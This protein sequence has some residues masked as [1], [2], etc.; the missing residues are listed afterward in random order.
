M[1]KIYNSITQTFLWALVLLMAAPAFSQPITLERSDMPARNQSY[2]MSIGDS[3]LQLDPSLTGP[4]YTWDFSNLNAVVQQ[5]DSFLSANDLPLTLRFFFPL[6]LTFPTDNSLVQYI[7]TPDSL[8]GISVGEAYQLYELKSNVMLGHGL[9]STLQGVPLTLQNQPADTVYRFPLNYGDMDSAETQGTFEFPGVAYYEQ[10]RKRI[11]EVDGWGTVQT[12]YGTF[13][14]L[15]IK[16]QISGRDSVQLD[17]LQ[18]FSIDVPQT[19]E[20]KWLAKD[21]GVPILQI[22][23]TTTGQTE[24]VS[25][26]TY[27]DSARNVLVLSTD[28]ENLFG[29]VSC[30]PNPATDQ[31]KIQWQQTQ[32]GP[33]TLS[34]YDLSGKIRY[35]ETIAGEQERRLS[36]AGYPQGVY[37]LRLASE[38]GFYVSKLVIR[39]E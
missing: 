29:S 6:S 37:L 30:F 9:G 15:R 14:V 2:R 26:I 24:I 28:K 13:D 18:G 4:A 21:E 11:N 31:V 17:T 22:N 16:T 8:A 3:L 10:N 25:R 34:L 5:K 39:P 7:Q 1:Y 23:T 12:P 32:S 36:V 19:T 38:A 20:Y 33:V 27:R 35:Q